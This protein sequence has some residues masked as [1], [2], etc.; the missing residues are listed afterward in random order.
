MK[1]ILAEVLKNAD[2]LCVSVIKMLL[3]N[4]VCYYLICNPLIQ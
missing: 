1:S 2:F 4:H 3:F